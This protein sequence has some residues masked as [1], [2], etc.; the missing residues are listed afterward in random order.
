MLKRKPPKKNRIFKIVQTRA[1]VPSL[2]QKLEKVILRGCLQH[3]HELEVQFQCLQQPL[4][5][6]TARLLTDGVTPSAILQKHYREKRYSFGGDMLRPVMK[7]DI[8]NIRQII[9]PFPSINP[10]LSEK[11]NFLTGL[12][13]DSVVTINFPHILPDVPEALCHKVLDTDGS[14]F[15]MVMTSGQRELFSQFSK[16]LFIDSTHDTNRSG[17]LL[18]FGLVLNSRQEGT[19]VFQCICKEE[20]VQSLP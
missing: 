9:P 18:L 19:L 15:L 3:N 16:R 7:K 10:Q 20:T 8:D 1:F 4:K 13:S 17:Y 14:D 12:A 5:Q 2:Q 11:E 6:D